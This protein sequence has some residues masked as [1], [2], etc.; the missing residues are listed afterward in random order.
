MNGAPRSSGEVEGSNVVANLENA[1]NGESAKS[2]GPVEGG[3]GP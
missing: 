3:A 1:V 2:E